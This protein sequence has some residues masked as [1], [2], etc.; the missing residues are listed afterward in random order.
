MKLSDLINL[1]KYEELHVFCEGKEMI[2]QSPQD[3][4][5]LHAWFQ[6]SVKSIEPDIDTSEDGLEVPILCV[7]LEEKENDNIT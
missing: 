4:D 7:D 5:V 6:K 1:A 3:R 2:S